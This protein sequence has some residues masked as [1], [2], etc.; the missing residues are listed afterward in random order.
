M[1]TKNDERE[2]QQAVAVVRGWTWNTGEEWIGDALVEVVATS[3]Y[4]NL[5]WMY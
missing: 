2:I 4:S 3:A 5:P 1:K